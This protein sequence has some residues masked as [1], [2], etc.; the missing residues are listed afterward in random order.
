MSAFSEIREIVLRDSY[1]ISEKKAGVD[2][3]GNAK[4]I[5][6][7]IAQ[8]KLTGSELGRSAAIGAMTAALAG[9]GLGAYTGK[10]GKKKK[11]A[12]VWAAIGALLGGAAGPAYAQIRK[13]LDGIPFDNSSFEKAPHK[14]GDKVYIGVAGSANGQNE[15]WFGDDMKEV[16][17][18]DKTIMLRHVDGKRLEKEYE[19]LMDKGLDVTVVGHSSGGA[20][21]GRFLKKH[22]EAKGY[23]LDPVSWT[24]RAY[25]KNALI[26]TADQGTRHGGVFENYVA[27]IGGR[28]NYE[29]PNSITFKGSHSNRNEDIIR[30]FVAK[31]VSPGQK[32]DP[33]H[34]VTNI[35]GNS[36]NK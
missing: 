29:G 26:F 30:D 19:R 24:G 31:G 32:F 15:S 7:S 18:K 28:W 2:L 1:G 11:R 33:R 12:A 25:P 17:G 6:D 16:L 22:P 9:A 13:Y 20:T 10:K 27:D 35:Y 4:Y 36:V 8:N 34:Y 3:A 14:K 21:V 23:M 5:I